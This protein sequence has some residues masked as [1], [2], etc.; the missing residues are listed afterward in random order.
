MGRCSQKVP[1]CVSV[2]TRRMRETQTSTLES[3]L[4]KRPFFWC[5]HNHSQA[6]CGDNFGLTRLVR[7]SVPLIDARERELCQACHGNNQ[8][9]MRESRKESFFT[10]PHAACMR[11]AAVGC[12]HHSHQT[13]TSRPQYMQNPYPAT[14]CSLRPLLPGRTKVRMLQPLA[15][16]PTNHCIES[17]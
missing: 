7:L 6:G 8:S 14:S 5:H 13:T 16:A 10:N 11:T 4:R 15:A 3:A 9:A 2:W 1:L 12:C 17:S